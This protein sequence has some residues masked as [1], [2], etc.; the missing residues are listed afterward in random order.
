ML[1]MLVIPE[2][3]KLGQ[4]CSLCG[5]SHCKTSILIL[6][7]ELKGQG[8]EREPSYFKTVWLRYKPTL[9]ITDKPQFNCFKVCPNF[10]GWT[11]R[12]SEQLPCSCSPTAGTV[13]HSGPGTCMCVCLCCASCHCALL[14]CQWDNRCVEVI[15]I[16]LSCD[17]HRTTSIF[18]FYES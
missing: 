6:I 4:K 8:R 5:S 12:E 9:V 2:V 16:F 11:Q 17:Y 1:R 18:V 7:M 10:L 15:L 13:R 3:K 14:C